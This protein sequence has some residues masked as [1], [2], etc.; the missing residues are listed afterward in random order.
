V[1]VYNVYYIHLAVKTAGSFPA[2]HEEV[3]LQCL[4]TRLSSC[5]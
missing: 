5:V 4:C 2:P 3:K 1:N